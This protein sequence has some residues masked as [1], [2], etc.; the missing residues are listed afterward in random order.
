MCVVCRS[1]KPKNQLMRIVNTADGAVLDETGKLNGRGIYICK[2]RECV[3]KALK[4]KG[5]AKQY[6]FS[7]DSLADKLEKCIEQ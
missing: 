5:F 3:A 7:L 4:G 2:C 1:F 6:G